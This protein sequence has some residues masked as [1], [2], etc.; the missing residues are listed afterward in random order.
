MRVDVNS[1]KFKFIVKEFNPN[2]KTIICFN[3]LS[4]IEGELIKFLLKKNICQAWKIFNRESI[5]NGQKKSIKRVRTY[6]YNLTKQFIPK[7]DGAYTMMNYAFYEL[8][9]INKTLF[10]FYFYL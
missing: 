4:Y 6:H 7:T 10:I 3:S 1:N 8:T 2:S 5:R 9:N